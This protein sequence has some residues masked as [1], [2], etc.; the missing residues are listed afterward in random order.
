LFFFTFSLCF[1]LFL[2]W[3]RHSLLL[4]EDWGIKHPSVKVPFPFNLEP[5][6]INSLLSTPLDF[7][8]S[9]SVLYGLASGFAHSVIEGLAF[10]LLNRSAGKKALRISILGGVLVG[11]LTFGL[12]FGSLYSDDVATSIAIGMTRE[13]LLLLFFVYLSLA[14]ISFT[15]R[16]PAL[17]YYALF[18]ALYRIDS[19]VMQGITFFG[20]DLGI[21]LY[22]LSVQIVF[23]I[24]SPFVIY[25][26]LMLDSLYW[27]GLYCEDPEFSLFKRTWTLLA[28]CCCFCCPQERES[29][30]EPKAEPR[31]TSS[32]LHAQSH[33][34]SMKILAESIE[35]CLQRGLDVIPFG[36]LQFNQSRVLGIGVN[37]RV[38]L[39]SWN[40]T[41]VAVKVLYHQEL[42]PHHIVGFLDEVKMLNSLQHPNILSVKGVCIMP[43][44]L[45]VVTEL[46]NETLEEFLLRKSGLQQLAWKKR[47]NLMLEM[48]RTIDFLHSLDPPLFHCDIKSKRFLL[49]SDLSVKVPL[50]F[51]FLYLARGFGILTANHPA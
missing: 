20:I 19:M 46:C 7:S 26:T 31:E 14:P 40:K 16:R 13:T 25:R 45:C 27:Q 24:I 2:P 34:S 43:P 8:G 3:L 44:T 37:S 32:L 9:Q 48:A 18:W 17:K 30:R 49:K 10:F 5:F 51:L 38:F 39:G 35:E 6:F 36:I 23:G 47:V 1:G 29:I 4:F 11:T 33:P 15:F 50:L 21:C 28:S 12:Q 41:P 42:A 22:Y